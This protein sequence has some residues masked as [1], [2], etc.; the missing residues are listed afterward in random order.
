MQRVEAVV[1]AVQK[2]RAILCFSRVG[3]QPD[4]QA[5][6]GLGGLRSGGSQFLLAAEAEN[7]VTGLG[8]QVVIGH[9]GQL[10]DHQ[11]NGLG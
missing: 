7:G 10:G 1:P 2:N 11:P 6:G 9:V 5:F 3:L 8:H 4:L